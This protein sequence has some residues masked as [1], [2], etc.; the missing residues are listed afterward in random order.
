MTQQPNQ[1]GLLDGICILDLADE[2][3]SFCTRLLADLGAR[4]IKVEKP[5]GDDSRK[6]GPFIQC[7]SQ[8]IALSF[9]YNNAGKHGVTL[10]LKHQEGRLIFFK[11][12]KH[13]DAVVETFPPGYLKEIGLDYNVLHRT[14]SKLIWVSVTGFGQTGPRKDYKTSDLIASACGGAMHISGSPFKSPLR[15]FGDQSYFTASLFAATGILLALR[16]RSKSGKGEHLDISLQE[17]VASTLEHVLIRYF[18]ENVIFRRQESL[19]WNNGFVILPCKDG[20]IHMTL[21]Q[22]WETLIEWMDDQEMA[23]DLKEEK[24]LDEAYRR[25][26][27]DHVVKIV[28][29]WTAVH[30]TDELF[31]LGQLMRFPWAPVQSPKEV[32]CNPQLRERAFFRKIED[33]ESG[34]EFKYPGAPYRLSGAFSSKKKPAPLPGEHNELIYHRELGISLK[35]LKRLYAEK[36]M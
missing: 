6:I 34:T 4:V 7:F 30:A 31:K 8:K 35:T 21:F 29:R 24:W 32:I 26:H 2:K 36:V 22:D 11:L 18:A 10:N 25:A 15:V 19:H 3:A 17:S 28:K 1:K 23:G 27:L 12:V 9:F 20:F 16:K 14:H 5:G 33:P 13:A